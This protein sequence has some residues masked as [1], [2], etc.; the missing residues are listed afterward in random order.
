MATTAATTTPF[1]YRPRQSR[2]ENPLRNQDGA[3][4]Y[5]PCSKI[6]LFSYSKSRF[7]TSVTASTFLGKTVSQEKNDLNTEICRC[8]ELGNLRN[9]MD[10]LCNRQTSQIDS[11]TYCSILQL[12]ADLKSLNDGRKVHSIISSSGVEIDSLL[13]SKLVFMYATCGDLGEGR[14][15]FDGI[16]KEK[17]FLWNLL[18]NEYA[19]IGNFR[20]SIRLFK[21][22][23]ELGIDANSYT[24]SCVFKC[25]AALGSV[26]EG[27]QVHGYLLKSGFDSYSAVGN[28]LIAFY[29]KCKKIQSAR[30]VFD[31]LSDRDTI[32]WNSMISGYV[33]NGLAEEGLKL[34]IQMPL[35]GVDLDLTTMI[36]ILPACAEIGSLYL[37]RALHGYGIKAHFD[38]EVTFNNTL[39]D[40][41]SK[42]GDLD[43]ATRVFVKMDKRSVVSWTS[44]MAGYTRE[45][46]YD[47]AIN[48]F[49]EMEEEGIKP[50]IFTITSIL[51]ACACNGSLESGKD[52]HNY[53]RSSNLQFHVFVANAIMDMYA[54]CGSMEDAR[55]VFDQMP[56]RDTVSW[57]TMIGGYSRNCLPNDALGLFIQMQNELKPNVV[58]MACVLPACA[59]LSALK[60]GQE[61]HSHVMRNGFFSDLYVANALVDMY[62]KCGALVHA[63]RLFDRMPT[64]D[65]ISWTVMISGYGMHGCGREVI[66]VFNEMRRTGVEPNGLS[67][68][69]ILYACSHSGLID[70][71]WRFF[72]IMKN[73]C[74]IEP[75]L[76]HYACM[77]DLLAR[78][79]HLTKAYKFIQ[80]MPIKPDSTVWGALL[81]GCRI[82]H[83][84]KLAERVAEQI[85]ELEPENTRYYVL[86]SNIYAEAE[87][88]EEVKKLR[89]RID[90]RSF[91]KKPECSWIEIKKRYHVFVSGDRSNPHAKK[92]E[93]FLKRVRTKMEVE[94]H[95]PKKRYALLNG[96]NIE[97]EQALCGHSE[98]MAMAFGILSLPSGKITRVTKNRDVC[99]DCH[100]MGKFLSKMDDREIVLRDS[101]RFHHFEHG[102]CSCRG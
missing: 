95:L 45:G 102:R 84:V 88:W 13:G 47:R 29:S 1:F 57:N 24:M 99:S 36:S 26:V 23:L 60:R 4:C 90:R 59:S 85:F 3:I 81:F 83:D 42:C 21:Q 92:I 50:D 31:E 20:E 72:N 33:S 28:S 66:S 62:V 48:L 93:S 25:F 87:K 64:K 94:G 38:S 15:V 91:R 71:G 35:S 96:G 76:D 74:K 27:E 97:K 65:L 67:F 69:S 77:V 55:S 7:S 2:T 86:L 37:C 89:E 82:H 49:K 6:T 78:A 79:G 30:E 70:E 40:L 19:K 80:M 43:A 11:R 75:K 73:D 61:I 5:R 34:F 68:I 14:R 63:R 32:S 46:Q 10:L 98:K 12:C 8:C 51:H 18:M 56:V 9:A 101:N 41:Y 58:T 44:M 22:M 100:E 39:L 16:Q 17:V 54:K 52:V 53:V